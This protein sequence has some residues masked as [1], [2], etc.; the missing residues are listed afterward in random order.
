MR[1]FGRARGTDELGDS[2]G[3]SLLA[4]TLGALVVVPAIIS[5]I[6]TFQRIQATQRLTRDGDVLDGWIGLV[7]YLV[8]SPAMSAYMQSGLNESWEAVRSGREMAPP[9]PPTPYSP[10]SPA[11]V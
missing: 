9:Y 1:D 5:L 11:G 3:T 2:P 8:L 7:L 6:H 4:I 10:P